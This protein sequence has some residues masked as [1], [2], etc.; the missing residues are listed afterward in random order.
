MFHFLLVN[1]HFVCYTKNYVTISL[2]KQ[3][4]FLIL[5]LSKMEFLLH[6]QSIMIG[7]F[8]DMNLKLIQLN[9]FIWSYWTASKKKIKKAPF[10]SSE[11]ILDYILSSTIMSISD[12]LIAVNESIN[13][14]ISKEDSLNIDVTI[15]NRIELGKNIFNHYRVLELWKIWCF[16]SWKE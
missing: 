14:K 9:F 8:S 12:G 4:Q 2:H 5:F 1:N 11:D 16:Y 6:H 7:C 15:K 13:Y 10:N 3:E